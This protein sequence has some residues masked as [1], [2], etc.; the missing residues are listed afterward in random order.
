M[1]DRQ[2]YTFATGIWKV[3]PETTGDRTHW[4]LELR[5]RE[6]KEISFSVV[7]TREKRLLWQATPV[8]ADWWTSLVALGDGVMLLEGYESPDIPM[9]TSLFALSA[10][11]GEVKWALPRHRLAQVSGNGEILVAAASGEAGPLRRVDADTGL[12]T[13]EDLS[14]PARRPDD[15]RVFP[16]IYRSGDPFFADICDFLY[17]TVKVQEVKIVEYLEVAPYLI[18]SYYI[19]ENTG[20]AQYLLIAHRF[21]GIAH[22]EALNHEVEALGNSLVVTNGLA[23]A[24]VRNNRE[25]L[26]FQLIP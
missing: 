4:G 5:D 11:E 10:G 9:P 18:I 26:V 7:D 20:Y 23:V 21:N 15:T 1:N 22:H 3:L 16:H 17:K 2:I 19:Y 12:F 24:A 13:A 14:V 25:L 6:R 8:V